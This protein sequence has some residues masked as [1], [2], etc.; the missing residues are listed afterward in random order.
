MK[1][2]T[3]SIIQIRA[4][5]GLSQRSL[6]L[7]LGVSRDTVRILEQDHRRASAV[8]IAAYLLATGHASRNGNGSLAERFRRLEE[9]AACL[10]RELTDG[11]GLLHEP[12][13]S[14]GIP[15]EVKT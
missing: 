3:E 15:E 6:A 2:T 10:E 14:L 12:Q 11:Y 13:L 7:R 8:E 4:G 1:T 9:K 5:A